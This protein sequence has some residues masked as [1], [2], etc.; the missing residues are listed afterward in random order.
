MATDPHAGQGR[1]RAE[2]ARGPSALRRFMLLRMASVSYPGTEAEQLLLAPQDLRT[3]D[4]SFA[5]EIYN[6]HFGLGAR[7]TDARY[8]QE[9]EPP[10]GARPARN[11][12]AR[13]ALAGMRVS[14]HAQSSRIIGPAFNQV[15]RASPHN[16][17]ALSDRILA[18]SRGFQPKWAR[19]LLFVAFQA[20][21]KESV[22]AAPFRRPEVELIGK[23]PQEARGL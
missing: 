5:T 13:A 2:L 17:W 18:G 20:R 14:R 22:H 8:A 21:G 15:P 12:S 19:L 6:G 3:A 9:H 23:S 1:S 4:P 16:A 11:I 7:I 10:K